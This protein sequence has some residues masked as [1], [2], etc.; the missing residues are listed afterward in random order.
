MSIGHQKIAASGQRLNSS[1]Y[2]VLY[3]RRLLG[4][5]HL[6]F[7]SSSL[8]SHGLS[9]HLWEVEPAHN[10]YGFQGS[11]YL[12]F[13]FIL[14][15]TIS[16]C[17]NGWRRQPITRGNSSESPERASNSDDARYDSFIELKSC[18]R[19][20]L[21]QFSRSSRNSLLWQ[22]FFLNTTDLMNKITDSCFKVWAINN[23][24]PL[25]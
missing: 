3:G 18:R 16:C 2:T 12:F 11:D 17:C 4:L 10:H 6:S 23:S 1:V 14:T 5:L 21:N 24:K 13:A 9:S 22:N 20:S 15:L 8:S 7:I 25:A 19:D